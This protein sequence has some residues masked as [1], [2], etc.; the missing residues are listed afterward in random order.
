MFRAFM[1]SAKRQ[2]ILL[3]TK[4]EEVSLSLNKVF[5]FK[6]LLKTNLYK[7]SKSTQVESFKNFYA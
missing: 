2:N 3:P 1:L 5:L 7:V 4:N 6:N